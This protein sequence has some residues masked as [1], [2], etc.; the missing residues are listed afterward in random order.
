MNNDLHDSHPKRRRTFGI[1]VPDGPTLEPSDLRPERRRPSGIEGDVSTLESQG[2]RPSRRRP[3]LIFDLRNHMPA[4]KGPQS[5]RIRAVETLLERG[6][7]YSRKLTAHIS[8]VNALAFSSVDG[9]FL[10]SGGDDLDIHLWDLHEERVRTPCCTL[11]G[12][13]RNIFVLS[14]SAH[15]RFLFSGGADDVVLKFDA[16]NLERPFNVRAPR[17]PDNIFYQHSGSIRGIAPH[18]VQDDVFI[19]G[20]EDGRLILHDGRTAP[21]T[22][23]R[24]QDTIQLTAEVTGVE[25]HPVME[26]VFAT[27]DQNGQ[28]CLRDTRMAFGPLVQRTQQGVVQIYNTKLSRRDIPHLSNPE[29]SS[30][31]FNHQ[32]TQL[33]VTMM[34]SKLCLPL[35]TEP[36]YPKNYF[37]TIY[38]LTD[39]DP[40]AVCS[41]AN[42]PDGT[43]IPP[44]ERTYANVCTM[45]HGGF[46]GPGLDG[47]A[48]VLYVAG[49]DDFRAYVWALPPPATLAAQRTVISHAEWDA[50]THV[51]VTAFAE[52]ATGP[53][54]I[55][56]QL[57]T[58][59]A[60]LGGHSSIVNT[61]LVHPQMLLA[62]T[63]G[64]EAGIVLHGA[65]DSLLGGMRPTS[66]AVRGIGETWVPDPLED[67]EGS[68]EEGYGGGREEEREVREHDQRRTIR[69]F[70]GILR[71]EG[72]VDVFAER[73]WYS[74]GS[75]EAV[76][77][78]SHDEDAQDD[79]DSDEA[80]TES[81]S[82]SDSEPEA[83]ENGDVEMDD[84]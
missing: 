8:C 49:S 55:P 54:C 18:P 32:G 39:A 14:F 30:I 79:S 38:S 2:F 64:I 31:A 11:Q 44:G 58:P 50:G 81:D 27:S 5:N 16:S 73:R 22:R 80:E 41:A 51:G 77:I 74:H 67:D 59:R 23:L 42:L 52:R 84:V 63:A 65:V 29:T 25:F 4:L 6:F 60:R 12:P 82:H 78:P 36:H 70:D 76:M 75:E 53:R 45:K 48:D 13:R 40:V 19:T 43:P 28:V 56:A 24:A 57:H 3:A 46:G 26:H 72:H 21:S 69:Q 37:P 33:G 47:E 61:V 10:A 66:A 35:R 1:E 15:N 62:A 34:V 17:S 7:P 20:S 83:N 71:R 68:G 9:R